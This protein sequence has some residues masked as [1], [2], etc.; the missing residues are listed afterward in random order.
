MVCLVLEFLE[1]GNGV[2]SF[3][4]LG[5]FW[6]WELVF[7]FGFFAVVKC[8]CFLWNLYCFKRISKH[9]APAQFSEQF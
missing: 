5:I 3:G 6:N 1:L 7:S 2:F 4:I 8:C 9:K